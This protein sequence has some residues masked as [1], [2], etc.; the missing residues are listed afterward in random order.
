M[1]PDVVRERILEEQERIHRE[2]TFE[3]VVSL[4]DGSREE[5]QDALQQMHN[6]G[7]LFFDGDVV[8]VYK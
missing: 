7:Y 4:L 2:L 3:E 5:I 1:I 8:M 6:D